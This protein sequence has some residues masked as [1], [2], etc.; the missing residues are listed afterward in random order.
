[1]K[2]LLLTMI[3]LLCMMTQGAWAD[4][5]DGVTYTKP[6][7]APLCV[8]FNVIKITKA[9]ELAYVCKH[10]KEETNYGEEGAAKYFYESNYVLLDDIDM[11]DSQSWIPLGNDNGSITEFTGDFCGNGKTIRIHIFGAKENYQGLFAKIGE[12]AEVYELTV[13]GKIE[14]TSSR[15]V[16]GICGEN[17][18]VIYNCVVN[19]D[20]S[21][22]WHNS[23]SAYSAKV[24]GIC[25]ENGTTVRFCCMTGKV[26]NDDAAV[27]G[28]VGYNFRSSTF[29]IYHNYGLVEHCVFYGEVQSSHE[30]DNIYIGDDDG[31][32]YDLHG[33]DLCD[34]NRLW[35][36]NNSELIST[37]KMRWSD[38]PTFFNA[39]DNPYTITLNCETEGSL[40]STDKASRPLRNITLTPQSGN[41]ITEVIVRDIDGNL[42]KSWS[43]PL[44]A[45]YTFEMPRRD[46]VITT[47]N[48]AW[49]GSGTAE[50]PYLIPTA[51]AWER[52]H[53]RMM[54]SDSEDA[55]VNTYFKQTADIDIRQGIG[56][57]GSAPGK[58]F[59]GIYDGDNHRLNCQLTNPVE[60]S[61]WAVAPFS[62]A[63]DATIKN[64]Y[65]TG[66][67]DGGI[68]S[69]GIVGH[70]KGS[71]T[72]DNC[73]VAADITC[74]GNDG[75]D[76]H[77][78][79]FVGHAEDSNPTIKNS[80]FDGKLI[81]KSNGKGD[82]R[83]GAFVGWAGNEVTITDCVENA[84]YEGT[85]SADQTAFCWKD[86][87][88]TH[89][90][91]ASRN[92]F[93]SDFTSD[94][95]AY[96]VRAVKSGT[97]DLQLD[98]P[99]DSYNWQEAYHGAMFKSTA[100]E[101]FAFLV[102][103][104][105]YSVRNYAIYFDATCPESW[106]NVQLYNGAKEVTKTST[107][108]HYIFRLTND[109]NAVI[110]ATYKPINWIDDGICA[111]NY[112]TIDY[113]NKTITI[114][115]PKELAL[116]SKRVHD[117]EGYSDWTILL[118]T[119]LD[120]SRYEWTPIG[121]TQNQSHYHP[122][123]GVFDGQGYTISG[124]KITSIGEEFESA[125]LFGSIL[126]GTVQ[127]VQLSNSQIMGKKF[128]GG[129]VGLL[130]QGTI[131]NCAVSDNVEV[132]AKAND[133]ECGGIVAEAI[134]SSLIEGCHSAAYL[135]NGTATTT[136]GIVAMADG[137]TTITN[138]ISEASVEGGTNNIKGY[139]CG[140]YDGTPTNCYYIADV[141]SNNDKDK[142]AFKVKMDDMLAEDGVELSYD[143]EN[144]SYDASGIKMYDGQFQL[145][146]DWYVPANGA[147]KFM[148]PESSDPAHTVSWANVKVNGGSEITPVVGVYCFTTAGDTSTEYEIT[149][150]YSVTI[151]P[152]TGIE[153][154]NDNV[155]A[156][157]YGDGSWFTL[158][159]RRINGKP[160]QSGIYINNG[161]KVVIK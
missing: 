33:D 58:N 150:M 53:S 22:D 46:V 48:L 116:L 72:I 136:G 49:E 8:N 11:G 10:F 117:G 23:S 70:T 34:D 145:V 19:A 88:D 157:Q 83:L 110:T 144:T 104:E 54:A 68:H 85:T 77:G 69:A 3:A 128:A 119:D 109:G 100:D 127:N 71:V 91:S 76:A 7:F 26:R 147:F 107:S 130:Y 66:S 158:D 30:Q 32:T 63:K 65:V 61:Y 90:Y 156:N 112:S 39:C 55:F 13:D 78:A 97:E 154:A 149:A 141:P 133:A 12:G 1:M 64:L 15:L 16:G 132:T 99:D 159:G 84:S 153:N 80:L 67:I 123:A 95:G 14:C 140:I 94:Y 73:R 74:T 37:Y 160:S 89:V 52:I 51:E 102:K 93:F 43:A 62:Y 115:N 124:I 44:E 4:K 47:V 111:T 40:T 120:M 129:I 79:G 139:I 50:D 18:G 31:E 75:N 151:A 42:I 113:T 21:S 98:F 118:G 114:N 28:L 137:S 27:G 36:Y 29:S 6:E 134:T 59:C 125:G 161:K 20:V 86:I 135:N 106:A 35:Q 9:S 25:G 155:N 87:D 41:K 103:G 57:T 122:F 81:A 45:N 108:E 56:V 38:I 148:L 138:N 96:K 146:D 105:F 60:G 2:K 24:G 131:K 121:S 143:A 142:R 5:W 17:L 82:I 101:S 92:V 126:R 152:V